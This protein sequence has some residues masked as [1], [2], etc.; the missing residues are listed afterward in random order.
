MTIT[1]TFTAIDFETAHYQGW[2]ICQVGLVRVV[3]GSIAEEHSWLVQPPENYYY[4][5]FTAIHGIHAEMTENE[6]GFNVIWERMQPY[7]EQEHVVAHN[8]LS[9]DFPVLNKTLHYYG[10]WKPD[11]VKHDTLRIYKRG[12]ARLCQEYNI[13]LQHHDALSDARAC[14]LLFMQHQGIDISAW[15]E[16]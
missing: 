11:F 16:G 13:P 1:E 6:P 9:F 12:L 15:R 14:A 5:Q 2:S 7:I 10:I 4:R 3:Q 8:G